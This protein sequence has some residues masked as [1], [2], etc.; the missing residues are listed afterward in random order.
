MLDIT[1]ENMDDSES[2]HSPTNSTLLRGLSILQTVSSSN[3]PLSIAD[4]VA[5]LNLAKPTIHRIATQLEAHGYLQRDPIDKRFIVGGELQN[6]SLKVI[7]NTS[8]GAPRHAILEALS[9]EVEETCNCTMLD[10]NHTVYFDRVECNWPIKVNLSPGSRL[11]LHAT[12]SGKLFLAHMNPRDRKRLLN[13]APLSRNTDRTIVSP[14]TLEAELKKVKADG[15]AYDNEELLRGMV[16][17]AVP[18]FNNENKICFTVAIHAPTTRQSIDSL[19]QF[20]PALRRA[21][22][23]LA[24]SYCESLHNSDSD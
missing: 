21:S 14:E 17:I 22:M 4:L 15:I 24:S 19:S 10:G 23:A 16:A 7:S 6:F 8:I 9:E 20:I 1:N 18:V 13:A 3:R 12:A 5:E 2:K 11:P